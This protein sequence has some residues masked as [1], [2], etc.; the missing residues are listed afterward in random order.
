M[1]AILALGAATAFAF[2][3][4]GCGV[5]SR[6]GPQTG[7][8]V[9][10][11]EVSLP[12]PGYRVSYALVDLTPMTVDFFAAPPQRFAVFS[13]ASAALGTEEVRIG[14]GDTVNISVFE[15]AGGGLFLPEGSRAGNVA[16]PPQQVDRSGNITIPYA[17][18]IRALGRT[19]AELQ[20]EIEEKLKA[21]AIEPQAIVTVTDRRSSDITILGEVGNPTR[22]PADPSG[23]RLLSALARAGGTRSPAFESII[24]VQRRGRTE[25]ALL[26]AVVTNP[27]QNINIA[28]GDII[29]VS[30][31]PRAFLVFGA[32]QSNAVGVIGSN[33][34]RFIFEEENLTIADGLAK[35]GGLIDERADASAV[36]L[37]RMAPR[38]ML[39]RAGVEVSRYREALIPTIFR[40]DLTQA[41][42]FFI[43]NNFYMQNKDIL[44][45]SNSPARD[46]EKF[47]F[48]IRD[49]S[50]TLSEVA[51]TVSQL[52]STFGTRR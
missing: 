33:N 24:T 8:V 28:P 37:Y 15:A 39:A 13:R 41:E 1:R 31:Q 45:V 22:F 16:I 46:L 10:S 11:A 30:R 20:R 19:P 47:L 4:A 44:Y 51:S 21:R 34:R 43:A 3:G 12:D 38:E 50:S 25:Q 48:L 23:T 2:V 40:V 29:F 9:R 52:R 6:D 42:G 18:S 27:A 14:A 36:F 35:A 32:T 17:G 49:V 5:I 7:E 26:T